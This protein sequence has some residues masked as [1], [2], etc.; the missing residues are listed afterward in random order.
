M[1]PALVGVECRRH[2]K[3]TAAHLFIPAAYR[4]CRP[5]TFHDS[6]THRFADRC[7]KTVRH[8]IR[9][10]EWALPNFR[11]PFDR[12]QSSAVAEECVFP[13]GQSR[14]VDE[15]QLGCRYSPVAYQVEPPAAYRVDS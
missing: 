6:L 15:L 14:V 10:P 5:W 4:P 13:D 1:L 9:D 12:V 11:Q 7:R 2:C 8:P 3:V